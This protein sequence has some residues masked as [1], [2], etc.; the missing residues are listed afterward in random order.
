[1]YLLQDNVLAFSFWWWWWWWG[2]GNDGHE[3]D[4]DDEDN[5]III[6]ISSS[7]NSAIMVYSCVCIM[8]LLLWYWY[9]CAVCSPLLSAVRMSTSKESVYRLNTTSHQSQILCAMGTK[10]PPHLFENK[11]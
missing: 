4:G 1:M 9:V 2:G 8:L 6:I 7:S 11:C 5:V 10:I 3:D